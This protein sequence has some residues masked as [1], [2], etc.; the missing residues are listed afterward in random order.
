MGWV[1]TRLPSVWPIR[2]ISDYLPYMLDAWKKKKKRKEKQSTMLWKYD[3]GSSHEVMKELNS[4]KV[5]SSTTTW[6]T[7]KWQNQN[8]YK[9]TQ[10]LT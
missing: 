10:L 8:K 6:L 3:S 2:V 9:S 5:N 7:S 4:N 1:A